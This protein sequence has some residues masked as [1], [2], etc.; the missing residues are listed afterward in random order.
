MYG[1]WQEKFYVNH[2]WELKG[3]VSG[4]TESKDTNI[5]ASSIRNWLQSAEN[6]RR[7]NSLTNLYYI[8][9]EIAGDPSNATGSYK[10]DS[11]M[12]H[13]NFLPSISQPT[14]KLY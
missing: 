9:F 1:Y 6:I 2:F 11:F 4:N 10:W 14:R 7:E 8:H 12:N 3:Y 13:T 5:M